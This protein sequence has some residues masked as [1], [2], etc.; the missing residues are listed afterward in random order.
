MKKYYYCDGES[1]KR[2]FSDRDMFRS[3]IVNVDK[4]EYP[5]FAGWKWDMLRSGVFKNQS[6]KSY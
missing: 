5:T 6:I 1:E 4:K 3:Y 2:N